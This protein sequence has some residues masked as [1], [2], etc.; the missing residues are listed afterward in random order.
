[1]SS[2][3]LVLSRPW[4]SLSRIAGHVRRIILAF[5]LARQ[6]RRERRMLLSMDDRALQDVG[7]NRGDAYA[8]AHRSFWDVPV[9]RLRS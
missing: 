1:M 4:F 9:D 6:V 3:A 8:E 2:I 5:G 7:F